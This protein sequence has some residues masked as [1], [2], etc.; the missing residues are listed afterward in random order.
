MPVHVF[1]ASVFDVTVTVVR[2]TTLPPGVPVIVKLLM[3]AVDD[4]LLV[5]KFVV[6]PSGAALT[7]MVTPC[8][9][10]VD[11]IE[12][13]SGKSVCGAGDWVELAGG[14]SVTPR[15]ASVGGGGGL[16][17]PPLDFLQL[18]D[19]PTKRKDTISTNKLFLINLNLKGG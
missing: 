11:V 4:M 8:V 9:G 17:P 13:V 14:F 19:N 2:Q 1:V 5:K 18:F 6:E 10:M 16:L 3:E 12:T 15:V 7:S